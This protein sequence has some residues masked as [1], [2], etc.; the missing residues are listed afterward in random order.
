MRIGLRRH[1]F[2]F[3]SGADRIRDGVRF[4]IVSLLREKPYNHRP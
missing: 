3:Q 4:G 2:G 1:T